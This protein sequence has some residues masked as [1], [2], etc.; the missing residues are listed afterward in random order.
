MLSSA[1]PPPPA[2]TLSATPPPRTATGASTPTSETPHRDPALLARDLRAA[3][4]EL[5]ERRNDRRLIAAFIWNPEHD[6]AA[7]RAIAQILSMPGPPNT[8]EAQTSAE[9]AGGDLGR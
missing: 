7:R 2:E 5:A 9:A 8:T 6:E 3:E 4:K 1:P